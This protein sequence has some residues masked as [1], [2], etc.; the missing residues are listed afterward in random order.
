MQRYLHFFF[1]QG[2]LPLL[3]FVYLKELYSLFGAARLK[4][5]R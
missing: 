5:E 2:Q 4:T 1:F 3:F